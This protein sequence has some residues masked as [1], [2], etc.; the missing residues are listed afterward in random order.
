MVYC[1]H[2][3]HVLF[4]DQVQGAAFSVAHAHLQHVPTF[5]GKP[6]SAT[7]PIRTHQK[8]QDVCIVPTITVTHS[9]LCQGDVF[10]I[11]H[12]VVC[13][14]LAI[15]ALTNH[16]HCCVMNIITACLVYI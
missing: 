6:T 7:T 14:Y 10:N 16:G 5:I 2:S 3:V 4:T 15:A 11:N 8:P 1:S 13:I 12:T 9:H